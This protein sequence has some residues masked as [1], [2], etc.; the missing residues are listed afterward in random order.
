MSRISCVPLLYFEAI[1]RADDVPSIG[2]VAI[3][4]AIRPVCVRQLLGDSNA[5][6]DKLKF[7]GLQRTFI[8]AQNYDFL[9]REFKRLT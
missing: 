7:S 6:N 3:D 2:V 5:T 9:H 8:P 4:V 1:L